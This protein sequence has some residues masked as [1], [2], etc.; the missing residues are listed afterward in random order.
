[1]V[2]STGTVFEKNQDD[3]K[4]LSQVAPL[5]ASVPTGAGENPVFK[6]KLDGGEADLQSRIREPSSAACALAE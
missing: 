6:P 5:Q 1:M 3:K 4:E 2:D